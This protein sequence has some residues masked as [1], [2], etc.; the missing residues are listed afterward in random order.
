MAKKPASSPSTPL[1][2]PKGGAIIRMYRIGHGDCFLIAFAGKERPVH[3][4]IDCGYKPKSPSYI[5]STPDAVVAN[6]REVTC[7]KI[8]V[9][10][11][12]HEHQDH[13]NAITKTRF[14]DIEIGR[15]WY[16]WTE[17]KDDK[18]AQQLRIS[19]GKKLKELKAAR[20]QLAAGDT[21]QF[22]D[23]V[24][25][26]ELGGDAEQ[27]NGMA[28]AATGGEAGN[29]GAM[30]LLESLC[31]SEPECLFP[32]RRIVELPGAEHVRVYP[33][34]PPHSQ[35]GI[36]DLEPEGEENFRQ[37]AAGG[38]PQPSFAM[39]VSP[40]NGNSGAPFARRYG[41]RLDGTITDVK[42][43]DW[44]ETWYGREGTGDLAE[45]ADEVIK[46]AA[47][48]RI[49][50][51]WLQGAGELAIAL[52]DFTNNSSLVLAF[53]I[54]EGGKVLLFAGDAQ[55]GNWVSWADKTFKN[56]K[57]EVDVKE[58]LSRTVLYKCGHHGSH[59]ATLK[60]EAD[61]K[62]P[63][64]G[65]LGE[66]KFGKEFTAMITSVRAWALTQHP[67]WDHPL[68]TIKSALIEKAAGRVLQTDT[69][70]DAL[71]K[72]EAASTSSWKAFQERAAGTD[73][74]FDL[75]IDP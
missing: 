28:L 69:D 24:L 45:E 63:S 71:Q 14:A 53:E 3:V 66:G 61:S 50:N 74:Y 16:A 48:R 51:D 31:Q 65:W 68:K 20:L 10:V 59:N 19:K 70:F 60:G 26:L 23:Q 41:E 72:P 47:F 7:G 54:G 30:N 2:P 29:K 40:E 36:R 46:N 11:I 62:L 8:D 12:T 67:P 9:V 49:D 38:R 75:R 57:N 32:H 17:D 64:L 6:I 58:L 42:F 39:A 13:L 34:G 18:L 15:I 37:I 25:E 27:F 4:L 73:L 44:F 56:G 33:L 55:R 35:E 1:D 43:N 5:K 52:G 22:V 21:A